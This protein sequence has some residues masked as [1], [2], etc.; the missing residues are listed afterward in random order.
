M[1]SDALRDVASTYAATIIRGIGQ[2]YPNDLRHK[3]T[4]PDDRPTPRE[5]HPAFY[6]CYD[7]HSAVEMHWALTR[8]VRL[9]PAYLPV[10]EA[11]G[12]LAEHLSAEALEREA[13]YLRVRGGFGRPY[14]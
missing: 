13:K 11:R 12:A 9:V 6:G 10:D 14:G 2:E 4:G 5:I 7:W 1:D 3:M 8:L